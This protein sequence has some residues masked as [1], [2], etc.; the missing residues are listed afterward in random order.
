M[1][2]SEVVVQVSPRHR[3]D[4]TGVHRNRSLVITDRDERPDR[5]ALVMADVGDQF[6]GE[7]RF[8]RTFAAN[9][10]PAPICRLADQRI[11]KLNDGFPETTEFPRRSVIGRTLRDV[12]CRRGRSG[13]TWR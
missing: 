4:Q 12:A 5:L 13:A 11:V 6:E 1:R 2:P 8:E 9:P 10:P 7:N 3:P